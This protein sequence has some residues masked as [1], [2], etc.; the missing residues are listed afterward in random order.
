MCFLVLFKKLVNYKDMSP[1]T[2]RLLAEGG[3]DLERKA[4]PEDRE[5]CRQTANRRS[6]GHGKGGNRNRQQ[7]QGAGNGAG[8]RGCK[9][10][11]Q[12]LPLETPLKL[13][14]PTWAWTRDPL[15]MSPEKLV[16]LCLLVF[17]PVYR[18]P[19]NTALR[20]ITSFF[21]FLQTIPNYLN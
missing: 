10:G 7:E 21:C 17:T 9:K 11:L 14:G 12:T 20:K 3:E 1:Q 15:I 16:F 18:S 19:A 4:R 2:A 6:E 13:G 5:L 8:A